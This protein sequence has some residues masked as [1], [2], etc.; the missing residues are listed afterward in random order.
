ML[1]VF[2]LALCC[3]SLHLVPGGAKLR[4]S[5]E[6][7]KPSMWEDPRGYA[8]PPLALSWRIFSLQCLK[9]GMD[10]YGWDWMQF[11]ARSDGSFLD[12]LGPG[13]Y[14]GFS[15]MVRVGALLLVVSIHYLL[16]LCW[17]V[18]AGGL[19]GRDFDDPR[20]D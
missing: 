1:R 9:A 19:L 16:A 8:R 15:L 12:A 5:Q 7:P 2:R 13:F 18:D 14:S 3:L 10:G 6:E 20:L 17:P 4:S 11:S